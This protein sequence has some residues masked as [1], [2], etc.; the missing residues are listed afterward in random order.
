M[1]ELFRAS[2]TTENLVSFLTAKAENGETKIPYSEL[3]AVAGCDVQTKGYCYLAT[4]RNRVREERG[5]I[6]GCERGVG[7]YLVPNGERARVHQGVAASVRRKVKK[8]KKV[9]DTVDVTKLTPEELNSYNTGRTRFLLIGAAASKSTESKIDQA[10]REDP[11]VD[12]PFSLSSAVDFLKK[13]RKK[14][15][16]PEVHPDDRKKSNAQ[17]SEGPQSVDP[18]DNE[19][20]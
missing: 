15:H 7:L 20:Q 3:T 8:G 6:W 2:S 13:A 12:G 19:R 16:P 4:A 10:V 17:R 11:A 1:T 18:Q 9:M 5:E 14:Q